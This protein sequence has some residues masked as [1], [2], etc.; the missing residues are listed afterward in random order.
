M[1]FR[2]QYE[3]KGLVEQIRQKLGLTG[4]AFG[5]DPLQPR[6][7]TFGEPLTSDLIYG[8]TPSKA[9][10]DKVDNFLIS[11]DL[12]VTKPLR[13]TQYT[14]LGAD[15]KRE[16]TDKEYNRYVQESGKRIYEEINAAI[17]SLSGL[18]QE[19]MKREIQSIVDDIRDDLRDEILNS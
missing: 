8:I 1:I 18:S 5:L 10:G 15:Q 19:E 9:K 12:V 6:L 11:N 4:D 3:T 7:N 16:L 2:Q 13:G 14:I 17:D